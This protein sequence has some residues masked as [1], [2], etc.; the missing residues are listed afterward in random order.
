MRMDGQGLYTTHDTV[1]DKWD[2]VIFEIVNCNHLAEVELI[3]L[4]LLYSYCCVG[5]R[6]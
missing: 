4:L 6:V 2:A 5:Q 1:N 3:A